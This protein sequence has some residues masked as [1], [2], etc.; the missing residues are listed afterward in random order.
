MQIPDKLEKIDLS[1]KIE[2]EDLF[3]YS[4][5]PIII[6]IILIIILV[7]I[8]LYKKKNKVI[9]IDNN[10]KLNNKIDIKDSYLK[11][12]DTLLDDIKNGRIQNRKAYQRL[13]KIIRNFIY[14]MTNIKVQ[15]C[16]LEDIS[17][18]DMPVLYEL[19]KEYYDPEFANIS[20]GNIISSIE[21]TREVI[22]RWN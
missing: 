8:I 19:V 21:K 20:K 17:K 11:I 22:K 1:S 7:L 18:K 5:T 3:T 13:S 6:G 16:T 4:T 9:N 12:L 15:N 10:V 14:E 2:L